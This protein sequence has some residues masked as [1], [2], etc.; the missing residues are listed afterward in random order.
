M[1]PAHRIAGYF[2]RA[3]IPWRK[4]DA[5]HLF[6]VKAL[7]ERGGTASE[8]TYRIRIGRASRQVVIGIAD[9]EGTVSVSNDVPRPF[10]FSLIVTA[11]DKAQPVTVSWKAYCPA[12]GIVAMSG[13]RRS[14]PDIPGDVFVTVSVPRRYQDKTCTV[15]VTG[16]VASG[17]LQV[18]AG[19]SVYDD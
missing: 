12:N 7:V 19:A 6:T 8:M 11:N 17:K 3:R 16:A 1:L 15:T 10:T 2:W 4:V 5:L 13:T 18:V 9:G 14:R